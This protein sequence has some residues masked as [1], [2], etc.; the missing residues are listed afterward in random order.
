MTIKSDVAQKV[1]EIALK[2]PR[3]FPGGEEILRSL[4]SQF[5]IPETEIVERQTATHIFVLLYVR[6]KPAQE[7]ILSRVRLLNLA[8]LD[9]EVKEIYPKDWQ[10]TWK[11]AI[12]P[13]PLTSKF[14]VVPLW[15]KDDYK[16]CPGRTPLIIDT[17][18]SFGTG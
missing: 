18:L 11:E 2:L 6:R 3:S 5:G 1:T 4:L 8:G 9:V 12:R 15:R 10:D 17:A 7:K 14:D 13:F 16:P